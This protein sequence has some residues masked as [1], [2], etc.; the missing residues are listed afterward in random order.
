MI[1]RPRPNEDGFTLVEMLLAITILGVISGSIVG[2]I[3]VMTQSTRYTL[4]RTGAAGGTVQDSL[5][6]S[7]DQQLADSYFSS[8]V[9]NSASIATSRPA[10]DAAP[11][12]VAWTSIVAFTWPDSSGA[13]I[14][15]T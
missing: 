14:T 12:G 9:Q 10:C 5:V 15:T 7:H 1:T 6:S 4:D 2:A 13:D 3:F 11:T 8:D